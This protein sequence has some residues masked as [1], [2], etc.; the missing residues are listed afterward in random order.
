MTVTRTNP[1]GVFALPELIT[2]VVSVAGGSLVHLSGQIAW[3]ARGQL[4]GPG[5]HLAQARQIARNLDACLASVGATR[6]DVVSETV[7]V[8]DYEPALAPGIL[9]AL[10]AGNTPP[11]ST[12]IPV[13]AL[14]FDGYLV[15]VTVVAAV[16]A[17]EPATLAG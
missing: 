2:Q 8:V 5:D 11:A 15:E 3:D 6:A 9:G 14:G 7:Y 4:V 10:R 1:E 17:P 13:P 12:L 16:P